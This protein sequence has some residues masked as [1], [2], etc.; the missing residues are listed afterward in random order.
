MNGGL[1]EA[2]N[3]AGKLI[4]IV[5]NSAGY[6]DPFALFDCQRRHIAIQFVQDHTIKNKEL[7]ESTDPDIQ[8][9][10]QK[11]LIETAQNPIKAKNF[12]RA[13]YDRLS[14]RQFGSD[15]GETHAQI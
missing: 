6:V 11:W 14:A 3:L 8:A 5:Q 4:A 15:L 7:M 10:R 12:V 2:V 1:H 9:K 13:R